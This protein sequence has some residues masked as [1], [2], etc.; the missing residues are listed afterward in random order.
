M[1]KDEFEYRF[2]ILKLE[3]DHLQ[4]AI[5]KYDDIIFKIRGWA[6]AAFSAFV[7]VSLHTKQPILSLVAILPICSFWLMEAMQKNFQ[8]RFI[9]RKARIENYLQSKNFSKAIS[10]R[11]F[12][13]FE[14]PDMSNRIGRRKKDTVQRKK[15]TS[16][17]RSGWYFNV[18]IIYLPLISV[19]AAV[20][21]ILYSIF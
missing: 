19:C 10:E 1:D 3:M 13:Q 17:Y 15:E 18:R 11:V 6:V 16:I 4:A 2:E 9:R 21:V 12:D 14:I 8:H 20:S 7:I 5:A